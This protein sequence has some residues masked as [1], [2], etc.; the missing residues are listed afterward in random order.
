MKLEYLMEY[1]IS[2][3]YPSDETPVGHYGN[4]RIY[5]FTG[6]SFEGP[7][8]KGRILPGGGDWLL[9]GADGI[10][11]VDYRANLETDDGALVYLQLHGINKVDPARPKRP[12]GEPAEYGDRYYMIT[13]VFET[14]DDRYEWLNGLVCVGEGKPAP[15]GVAHRI[16]ALAND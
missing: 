6:G 10:G 3:T 14:G 4:R 2:L 13:P 16:Y 1:Y 9:R 5:N 7:R 12:E 15:G 11:R 8:L